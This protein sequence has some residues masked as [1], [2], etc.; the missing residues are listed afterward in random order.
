MMTP[1]LMV[2]PSP[3]LSLK[4]PMRGGEAHT[5]VVRVYNE[6]AVLAARIASIITSTE[7]TVTRTLTLVQKVAA[8]APT[9]PKSSGFTAQG[10]R[11]KTPKGQHVHNTRKATPR[12][13][14]RQGGTTATHPATHERLFNMCLEHEDVVTDVGGAIAQTTTTPDGHKHGRGEATWWWLVIWS[15]TWAETPTMLHDAEGRVGWS[16]NIRGF[17]LQVKVFCVGCGGKNLPK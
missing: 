10:K 16:I 14:K 15:G 6:P 9:D 4:G 2:S 5:L 3:F 7:T 17:L 1:H 12:P 13:L 11:K 8:A